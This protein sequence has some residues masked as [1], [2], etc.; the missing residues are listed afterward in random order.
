MEN[1]R[2]KSFLGLVLSLVLSSVSVSAFAVSSAE[3]SSTSM[4]ASI[5]NI[6]A[7]P[8]SDHLV[9]NLSCQNL[10]KETLLQSMRADFA[11]INNQIPV[12]NWGFNA[13]IYDIAGCWSLS[14]SQRLFY[15]L[16]GF[17]LRPEHTLKNNLDMIGRWVPVWNNF[18]Y[19]DYKDAKTL[20]LMPPF[21]VMFPELQ[22]GYEQSVGPKKVLRSFKEDIEVYQI[23]RFH[24]FLK[25]KDYVTGNRER[26][27]K[28][29]RIS[30]A[31]LLKNMDTRRLTL[32]NLRPALKSQHVVLVKRYE[33][34]SDHEILFKV[35]DSNHPDIE[36]EIFY[37]LK[38]EHFY[39]PSIVKDFKIE[40]P[41]DPIGL[42]VVD[43]EERE[44]AL[45]LLV[46]Y[47]RQ[48][49]DS[50]TGGTFSWVKK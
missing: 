40:R 19:I 7:N 16:S 6:A 10:S 25:N 12:K 38:T 17:D 11:S 22:R 13:G 29:N 27:V 3:F 35:Y 15:Y 43:E 48:L 31:T 20:S 8:I 50:A 30:I 47:Y 28:F 36:N 41:E 21:Q 37:N 42:F 45:D 23:H 39:A 44:Q 46:K 1:L 26:D 4:T 34:I 14:R 5:A 32:V 18:G 49:C 9:E 24:Q 2:L 33:K